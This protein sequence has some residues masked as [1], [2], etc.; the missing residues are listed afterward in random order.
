M[1]QPDPR[2][3][4]RIETLEREVGELVSLYRRVLTI[5]ENMQG[6]KHETQM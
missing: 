4:E 5:L 2:L 1:S 6:V 3:V